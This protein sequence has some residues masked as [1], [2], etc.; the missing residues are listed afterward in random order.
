MNASGVDV[1]TLALD[2]PGCGGQADRMLLDATE[3]DRAARFVFE[4]DRRR[5]VARRAA[6]RRLLAASTEVD[7]ASIGYTTSALGRLSLAGTEL[8]FSLA[9]RGEL[10]LVALARGGRTGVDIE[11]IDPAH[12]EPGMLSCYLAPD[13][14]RRIDLA[15]QA[16]DPVP[17]FHWWTIVEAMAKARGCGLAEASPQR[18]DE[19]WL[20]G[21]DLPDDGGQIRRWALR[22][23]QPEPGSCAALV[24]EVAA[25][26]A[27]RW[28]DRHG[29]PDTE[30]I[31]AEPRDAA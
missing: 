25:G 9:H 18:G 3:L 22:C 29:L 26:A 30:G 7:A 14:S 27:L 11:R 1:W 6:L 21:V 13:L 15:L 2:T 5:F 16:G 10:A 17:F 4:R 28:H 24:F 12:A 23:W 31:A 19:T 20:D 8:D